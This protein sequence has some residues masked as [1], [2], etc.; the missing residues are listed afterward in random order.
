MN[1][2]VHQHIACSLTG[3]YPPKILT[4]CLEITSPTLKWHLII[5]NHLLYKVG[6]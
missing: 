3:S 6:I 5:Q 2:E 4:A 1:L